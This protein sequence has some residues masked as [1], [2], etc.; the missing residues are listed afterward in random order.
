MEIR[1]KGII[2]LLFFLA[3]MLTGKGIPAFQHLYTEEITEEQHFTCQRRECIQES[4]NVPL[5]KTIRHLYNNQIAYPQSISCYTLTDNCFGKL[6]FH[7]SREATLLF[8]S[9][10]HALQ[11]RAYIWCHPLSG[12]ATDYYVYGLKKLLI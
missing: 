8:K 7:I 6:L 4:G 2:L 9:S 12:R 3:C 1:R 10:L 5:D 11:H